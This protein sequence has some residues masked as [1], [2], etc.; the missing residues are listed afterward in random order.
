M[1]LFQHKAFKIDIVTTPGPVRRINMRIG[2]FASKFNISQSAIRYYISEGILVPSKRNSQYVFSDSDAKELEVILKLK[3]LHFSI[4]EIQEYLRVLRLYNSQDSIE[5]E[6]LSEILN[7]KLTDLRREIQEKLTSAGNIE[8]I[9]EHFDREKEITFSDSLIEGAMSTVEGITGI[10]LEFAVQLSCPLCQTPFLLKDITIRNNKIT[11]GML[12]CECCYHAVIED[13]IILAPEKDSYYTSED[14]YIM[15]YREI[16]PENS[17]FVFFEYM[18][19]MSAEVVN[20]MYGA[21]TYMNNVLSDCD[22]HRKII[23]VPDLASHFLYKFITQPYFRDAYIIVS[24]FS[25][26]NILSMKSHIDTIAPDANIIYIANTVHELPVRKGIIDLWIDSIS[27]YNFAFFHPF[28]LHEKIYPYMKEGANIIGLTK[29]YRNSAKSVHNIK[30]GYSNC[31]SNHGLLSTFKMVLNAL[32]LD[33]K[34]EYPIGSTT[35][36]GPYYEYHSEGEEHNY[37]VYLAEK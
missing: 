2:E 19:D 9:L 4:D 11:A 22:L 13:G 25:K 14:F 27:S 12:T 17:D 24:G 36:P 37:M 8:M 32:D 34:Y 35:S 20:L 6:Y 3:S 1:L 10:P 21:Y 33:L 26:Q 29:Y 16:P 23:F 28:S 15:H 18:N 30:K 5:K 31:V 7:K